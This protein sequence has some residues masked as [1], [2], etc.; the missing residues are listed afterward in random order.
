MTGA[1]AY[2]LLYKA[3]QHVDECYGYGP[4]YLDAENE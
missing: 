4:V 3:K 1:E 2:A